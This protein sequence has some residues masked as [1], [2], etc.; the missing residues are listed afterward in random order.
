[1]TAIALVAASDFNAEKFLEMREEG[2]FKEIYAVDG[3]FAHLE[4]IGVVPDMALGDFDSLGYVPKSR[5]VIRFPVH[6]D[7][8]DLELALERARNSRAHAVYI[9]GALGGRLDHTM[10]NMQLFASFAEQEI[11]VTVV[12]T[13]CMLRILVGPDAFELPPYK[14][15]IVSVFSAN[16]EAYGVIER[17]MEYPL[18]DETLTNRTSL[19]LSNELTGEEAAVGVEEGTLYVFYPLADEAPDEPE[20]EPQ[21][22]V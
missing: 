10:A 17:G 1:M 4:K 12:G 9:F 16:D 20:S 15:G 6:K 11:E 18:D 2:L 21:E 13:D 8:S 3:G 14:K 19:G 7:K 22:S 5:R